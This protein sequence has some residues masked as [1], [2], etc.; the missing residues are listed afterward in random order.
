Q[1]DTRRAGIA[2][3][4]I[5][6]HHRGDHILALHQRDPTLEA[7]TDDRDP[8]SLRDS[9]AQQLRFRTERAVADRGD[10]RLVGS[11]VVGRRAQRR[12]SWRRNLDGDRKLS[13][14]DV[15]EPVLS[16]YQQGV[17]AI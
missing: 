8:A 12:R 5:V 6:S 9:V 7:L 1:D 2:R 10:L 14:P 17:D 16:R 13:G 11:G 3:A 4:A 15:S